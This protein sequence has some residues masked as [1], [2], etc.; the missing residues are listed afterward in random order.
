MTTPPGV[1]PEIWAGIESTVN[2][3]GDRYFDQCA[4]NGHW[5]R[6]SSDLD[7]FVSLGIRALRCPFLW[8]KIAPR[9][10]PQADW[11]LTDQRLDRLQRLNLRPIAGLVH[12]GSGPP[13]TSL[14]DPGFADGLS[15]Y[16]A[17][18]AQRYPWVEDYT[19]VNEP[20]TT[21][22]F[23]ALYGLWYPHL[24][25]APSFLRALLIQCRAIVLAMRAIRR[26]NPRARLIQTEDMGRTS[27]T[28]RLKYQ[29]EFENE[30][31]WLSFDLL[32]GRV[33]PSHPMFEYLVKNGIPPEEISFFR[34]HPTPPDVVG[35]NYYVTSDRMLDERLESYPECY[36]GGNSLE[37][38][39]D[40]ETV[41]A[42]AR[43]ITGHKALLDLAHQRYGLPVAFTEVHLGGPREE[44]LRWLKEAWLAAR[45]ARAEG[46][47]ARAITV[48]SL[49]GAYDWNRLVTQ[50]SGFYEPGP[51]DVRSA[52]LPRPT[53]LAAMTR[54]LA[55]TG[56]YDH[57][58]LATPGWWRRAGRVHY[59]PA[60]SVGSD[61][62]DAPGETGRLLLVVGA[63]GTLGRAFSRLCGV[64]GLRHV[65]LKRADMDIADAGSVAA[66]LEKHQPW[67]LVNAAG[68]VRVD[69]AESDAECCYRE[70]TRG[71][72]IL[73]DACRRAGVRLVTFSSDLVFSGERNTPYEESDTP[74]PLNV[75]GQSKYRAEQRVLEQSPSSLVVRTGAFFGPWDADNFLYHA[76]RTMA[77]GE[78]FG[79]AA[80]TTVSPTYVPDLVHACLD[81]LVDDENGIWHLA[82]DGAITW[83]DL[84]R[85]VARQSG[86]DPDLVKGR[87]F[88]ALGFLAPRPR[89]SVLGSARARLLSPLGDALQRFMIDR[90]SAT[91]VEGKAVS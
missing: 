80:D 10:A 63:R 37:R 90:K 32:C 19:P 67:A 70:N 6:W 45:S 20:L 22:R 48:W 78:V 62:P 69:A 54:S 18:F 23:S 29:A 41:R 27:S 26:V 66:A 11:T 55:T 59:G 21:A 42:S 86:F 76:L 65:L 88:T 39:A 28:P 61:A 73:A 49:L 89:F 84:A 53:A 15:A 9:G 16:A 13:H 58:V 14:I 71:P 77:R 35:L 60:R 85:E 82:N 4:R 2:R 83:A 30:R 24:H 47:D 1:L 43:G 79:A 3:V 33:A 56:A 8:E 44:Q 34:D 91:A 74:R 57:P 40:V 5:G 81:L 75:Y 72:A 68:Y 7:R 38:Y 31:R 12:H 50:E 25:D 51:Y 17:A 46:V 36:H 52:F 64:R 87:P